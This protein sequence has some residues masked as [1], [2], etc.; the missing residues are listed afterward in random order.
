VANQ[1]VEHFI[2][3]FKDESHADQLIKGRLHLERLAYFKR[4]EENCN[5]GRADEADATSMWLQPRGIFGRLSVPALKLHTEITEADLAEPIW[6]GSCAYDHLHLF[7]LYAV[8][9]DGFID[10]NEICVRVEFRLFV[11]PV[12]PLSG[13]RNRGRREFT[14]RSHLDQY[15]HPGVRRNAAAGEFGRDLASF[16]VEDDL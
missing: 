7:F 12:E 9:A 1:V 3:F 16:G 8:C 11:K 2:K 4:V 14:A 5:D 15:M 13:L 6:V 10:A